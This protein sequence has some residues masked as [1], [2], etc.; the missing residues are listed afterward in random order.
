M[1]PKDL[2][3]I[4]IYHRSAL[5]LSSLLPLVQL[6]KHRRKR[7]KVRLDRPQLYFITWHSSHVLQLN[8][9]NVHSSVPKLLSRET[10]STIRTK[11]LH[12]RRSYHLN[13]SRSSIWKERWARKPV[14]PL[15]G[16][17]PLVVVLELPNFGQQCILESHPAM[18]MMSSPPFQLR[19]TFWT[20]YSLL[21]P[22]SVLTVISATGISLAG[23]PFFPA[24]NLERYISHNSWGFR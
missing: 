8:S 15:W 17:L 19:W 4:F 13:E 11:G 12:L 7:T 14:F 2:A 20:H 3:T 22:H 16:T 21:S 1:N 24:G 5:V 9:A 23:L 18:S 6:P 10:Y